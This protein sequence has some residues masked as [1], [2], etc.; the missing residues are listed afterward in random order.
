MSVIDLKTYQDIFDMIPVGLGVAAM[1]GKLLIYNKKIMEPGGYEKEDIEALHSVVELYYDP[2]DR[3][4]ALTLAKSDGFIDNFK[5]RFRK[6]N[7]DPY[8]TLMSLRPIRFQDQ[9]GWLATV[10][11]IDDQVNAEE[12]VKKNLHELQTLYKFMEDHELKMSQLK[13]KIDE[14][15]NRF[16]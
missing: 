8:Y 9:P 16:E 6:K 14:L 5:V 7:G 13:V 12:E 11:D 10:L 1:D 4:K 15:N 3:V 2:A